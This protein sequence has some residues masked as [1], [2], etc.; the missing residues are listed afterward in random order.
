MQPQDTG[1]G[2]APNNI[3]QL[4]AALTAAKARIAALESELASKRS[5][6]SR[7]LADDLQTCEEIAELKKMIWGYHRAI[8]GG[9]NCAICDEVGRSEWELEGLL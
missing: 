8:P 3:E 6:L 1:P 2:P 5:A 4:S 9:C 7:L